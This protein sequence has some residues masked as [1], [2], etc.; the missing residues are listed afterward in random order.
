MQLEWS[1]P[2][3]SQ[4]YGAIAS[5]NTL[6]RYDMRGTGLSDRNWN[7]SDMEAG[8]VFEIP[9]VVDAL[10]LE[11]FALI[12]VQVSCIGVMRYAAEHPERVSRIVLLNPFLRT[13]D[14]LNTPQTSA[15]R[16]AGQADFVIFTEAIGTVAFGPSREETRDYGAY[17]R[18]SRGRAVC[19]AGN[20]T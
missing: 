11:R 17:I 16:A 9:E 14:M 19:D 7:I 6:V 8:R 13:E 5:R 15:L 18:R 20:G 4:I 12:G 2:I 3:F 1:Q 10:H